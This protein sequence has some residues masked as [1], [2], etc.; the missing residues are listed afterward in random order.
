MKQ[1]LTL[2][3]L[4]L[5]IGLGSF[6]LHGQELS[7]IQN[8]ETKDY[9]GDNQNWM[10]AQ[11]ENGLIYVANNEGLLEYDGSRWTLY[12]S[13]SSSII[14]SVNIAG[15]R[16]YTGCFAEIGYWKKNK[17][18]VLE[19]TS[20]KP[21]FDQES[22]KDQQFWNILEHNGWVLFQTSHQIL[23]YNPSNNNSYAIE[24]DN[25]I[26]KLF[27]IDNEIYYHVANEGI[28]AFKDGKPTLYID[29]PEVISDRIINIFR[30]DDQLVLLT[31]TSGL[32]SFSNDR[33]Q[34]WKIPANQILK[35]ANIFTAIQLSD[36]SLM[37]GTISKGI[38]YLNE[39]G[40]IIYNIN[41]K[42]GLANNTVLSLFEDKRKNV[43]VGLDNGITCI[44]AKSPIRIFVDFDGELGTV[45]ATKVHNGY[46]YLGT[47]QGLFCRKLDKITEPFKIIQGTAGQV[48]HLSS[49]DGT[50]FCGHHLG[51]FVVHENT[52]IQIS[53]QLGAWGIRRIP[54]HD[55][56]LLQGNYNGLYVLHKHGSNWE[57]RNKIEGFDISSRYFEID[58]HN[59]IWVS[60]EHKGVFKLK[61]ND[62]LIR[63]T[64]VHEEASL[65]EGKKSSLTSYQGN[66]IY[67][68]EMGVFQYDEDLRAF[69]KDTLLTKMVQPE[70]SVSGKMIVDVNE[71]LWRFSDQNISYVERDNLT[72]SMEIRYI[73][74]PSDL[75]KGVSGFEN[76][77]YLGRSQ[78]LFGTANGYLKLDL[79][80]TYFYSED[81]WI[82]L[83]SVSIKD[84]TDEVVRLPVDQE[85]TF[86]HDQ[87]IMTF[88]YSVPV[89]NKFVDVKYQH[90]MNGLVEGWSE[91]SDK[92][93]VSF[94][95]LPFGQYQLEVRAKIGNELSVNTVYYA[96]RVQRPWYL[97]NVAIIVYLFLIYILAFITHKTY[98]RHY[99]KKIR[100]KELESQQMIMKVNNEKLNQ[101]IE[102][103]NR[104]LAIS[105][106]SIIKKNEMLNQIKTELERSEHDSNRRAITLL[107]RNLNDEE[108]WKFFEKAFNNAD[109]YFMDKLKTRHPDLTHNDLR[110]CTYLRLN[111]SS[112]EIAPLLNITIKSVET[113]R[114]RLR[115]KM[116]LEHDHNLIDYILEF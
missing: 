61:L 35:N 55:G 69:L 12:P 22:L 94:E 116:N 58:Q 28:Y 60:H 42:R 38:I 7:P 68:N 50:L 24:A 27:K 46:F 17:L 80:D 63:V 1:Q 47:N 90:K 67:A 29:A 99:H 87:G 34:E 110:F 26:Y 16:I 88:S 48:W 85:G 76:I 51:T 100:N 30:L 56:L 96:F 82:Q 106:M 45:Y 54:N 70:K 6:S 11:A 15:D 4:Q 77:E 57:V 33:L 37:L 114:Y 105:T 36:K 40:E 64:D 91:W 13:P 89:Y 21:H 79:S 66:I 111:L 102:S 72:N 84:R 10:I 49:Q 8:F 95:N 101:E 98:K 31:R 92:T 44:N 41:Q 108:D 78:Y 32:Y 74:I 75:R 9:Q 113:K 109:K 5:S 112:K 25:L 53:D 83:T 3:L 107:N 59:Q 115:Q 14:R 52:A 62:S 23:L 65:P 103:K 104:E 18:G 86:D 81:H 2:F 93:E 20:L 39:S 97:S 73:P 19:Y 71:R 43:W